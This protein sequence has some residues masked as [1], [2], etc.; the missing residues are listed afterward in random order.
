[1]VFFFL[2]Y[3]FFKDIHVFGYANEESDDIINRFTKMIKYWIKN[4]YRNIGAV[5]FHYGL[6]S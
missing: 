5:V 3:L 1:M 2:E 4:I 6:K